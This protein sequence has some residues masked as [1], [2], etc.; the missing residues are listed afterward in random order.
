MQ[1]PAS[2]SSLVSEGSRVFIQPVRASPRQLPSNSSRAA[3]HRVEPY[4]A[5]ST[6]KAR[7]LKNSYRPN[8]CN[9]CRQGGFIRVCIRCLV[10]AAC[11]CIDEEHIQGCLPNRYIIENNFVC[12]TCAQHDGL[13]LA[14]PLPSRSGASSYSGVDTSP[15]IMLSVFMDDGKHFVSAVNLIEGQMTGYYHGKESESLIISLPFKDLGCSQ[16]SKEIKS[17]RTQMQTFVKKHPHCRLVFLLQTHADPASGNLIYGPKKGAPAEAVL[18]ILFPG[19]F[20]PSLKLSKSTLLL[21][22]CGGFVAFNPRGLSEIGNLK[23][24]DAAFAPDG[25]NIDPLLVARALF[26]PIVDFYVMGQE[27][28]AKVLKRCAQVELLSHAAAL[29]WNRGSLY[30]LQG[31]PL[32]HRPNGT[33]IRCSI[34]SQPGDYHTFIKETGQV[35]FRCRFQN[36]EHASKNNEKR[37]WAVQLLQNDV[38]REILEPRNGHYRSILFKES[39]A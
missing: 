11:V 26:Y 21:N 37:K 20:L 34:C 23:S 35:V 25:P 29:A 24:F 8:I 32:R 6:G 4:P 19:R 9:F 1:S 36:K 2:S 12:P 13:G 14:Y 27:P 33:P 10:F 18:D 3:C 22:T 38:G 28:V 16:I 5:S 15:L 17:I 31:A 30:R 7:L 39:D